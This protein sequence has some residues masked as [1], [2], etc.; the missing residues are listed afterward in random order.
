MVVKVLM[1]RRFKEG[2]EKEVYALISKMRT[3]AMDQKGYISG[4]T[5]VNDA[6]TKTTMVIGTWQS[7]ED[8]LRWKN[9]PRRTE[10]E[11]RLEYFLAGPTEY[12]VYSYK[13]RLE[14]VMAAK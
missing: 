1:K 14:R 8:W 13:Y 3:R 6:D 2:K 11:E 4:E 10:C 12:E 9:D 5:L 7:M